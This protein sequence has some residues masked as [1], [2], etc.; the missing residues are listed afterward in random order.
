MF[1]FIKTKPILGSQ[2]YFFQPIH[3]FCH[4]TLTN[5]HIKAY[6]RNYLFVFKLRAKT[7]IQKQHCSRNFKTR[8]YIQPEF[9]ITTDDQKN[10]ETIERRIKSNAFLITFTK[11]IVI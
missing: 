9:I 7:Q 2:T 11:F 3:S 8:N 1:Y 6:H 4:W 5:C 10:R